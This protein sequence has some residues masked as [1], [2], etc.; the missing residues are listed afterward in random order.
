MNRLMVL[1]ITIGYGVSGNGRLPLQSAPCD[2]FKVW[3]HHACDALE[4][5]IFP[6]LVETEVR[7]TFK[8]T[9][10]LQ[11]HVQANLVSVLE[12]VHNRA[13]RRREPQPDA[14]Y[15]AFRDALRPS[16]LR[17]SDDSNRRILEP[18]QCGLPV[19]GQPDFS[20]ELRAE[21]VNGQ[22]GQQA[23]DTVR[24]ARCN[25]SQRMVLSYF[26][27]RKRVQTAL[28]AF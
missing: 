13:R 1:G 3:A 10:R 25:L 19:D 20:W 16:G 28:D 22:R 2:R 11:R 23:E 6:D 18:R 12:T 9:Q 4:L 15:A 27:I 21:A 24:Y 14:L 17:E 8:L 7:S 26:P 5:C